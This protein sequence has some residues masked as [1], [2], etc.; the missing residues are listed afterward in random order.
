MAEA[1]APQSAP[2]TPRRSLNECTGYSSLTKHPQW[3][4]FHF[5]LIV[6]GD[7]ERGASAKAI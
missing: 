2:Y 4:Y 1:I 5:G 3:A 6:T 7:T